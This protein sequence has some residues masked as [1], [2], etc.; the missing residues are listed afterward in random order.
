[1]CRE[2]SPW[3][4]SEE[5]LEAETHMAMVQ[6]VPVIVYGGDYGAHVY[7][8]LEANLVNVPYVKHACLREVVTDYQGAL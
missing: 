2:V 4:A 7:L 6:A 3:P 5:G 1:M 8:L